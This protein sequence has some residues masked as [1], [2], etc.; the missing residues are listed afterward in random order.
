M[1]M[2]APSNTAQPTHALAIPNMR[3]NAQHGGSTGRD[4]C[5]PLFDIV[6]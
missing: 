1:G 2:S 5:F 4:T 6:H 3:N